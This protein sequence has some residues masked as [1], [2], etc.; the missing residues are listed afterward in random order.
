[1]PCSWPIDRTCLP[2]LPFVTTDNGADGGVSQ[3]VYDS[4]IL[5]Q[6]AAEDV[7]T[8]ILWALSGRQYGVCPIEV[9]PCPE[10]RNPFDR[11]QGF[12]GQGFVTLIWNGS[13]WATGSC[14]C[15]GKCIETGPG[16]VHLPGPVFPPNDDHPLVVTLGNVVLDDSEWT[17]E[18][19]ALFRR[20]GRWPGQHRGRPLG[21]NG[22]WSVSYFKGTPPP[23]GTASY[24]G[25]LTNEIILSCNNDK[26]C[27]LPRNVKSVRRQGVEYD[28]Y[29]ARGIYTL[30]QTG[31]SE[32]DLWLAAVN[33][34]AL[35]QAPV[36]R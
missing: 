19:D 13:G 18:G 31:I 2:T 22:T 21:E 32:I 15:M 27:R 3:D 23:Q 14:A 33:P 26:K 16:V 4:A 36:V 12:D 9:R 5:S 30:G 10:G 34:R 6:L 35:I 8:E 20:D 11:S 17:L 7:A 25:I 1:M 28:M 24:L 29:D